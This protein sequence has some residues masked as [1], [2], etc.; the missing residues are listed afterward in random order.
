MFYV[1]GQTQRNR[2]TADFDRTLIV[3]MSW[4]YELHLVRERTSQKAQ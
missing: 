3:Q 2:A 1:T 4:I